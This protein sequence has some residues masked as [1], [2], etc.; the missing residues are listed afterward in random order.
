MKQPAKSRYVPYLLLAPANVLFLALV[1]S[2]LMVLRLSF[3][4]KNLEW[5]AWTLNNYASLRDGIF[6]S[7]FL[8]TLRL[9]IVV[10]AIVLVISFP[11]SLLYARLNSMALKRLILFIILLPLFLNQLLQS[12]GWIIL[13]GPTGVINNLLVGNGLLSRPARLLYSEFGVTIA[14]V[15]MAIPLAV[16]PISSAMRNIPPSYEEAAAILGARRLR[17]LWEVVIPLSRPG[18][19]AAFLLVSAFNI[20]AFVIPLLLG[21]GRVS[22]VPM[23][24]RDQMGPLL[25]WPQGAALAV[26]LVL[27]A[28]GAQRL[29]S[30]LRRIAGRLAS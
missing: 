23:L 8:R 17:V 4:E 22:T 18:I 14:M 29:P 30:L 20:S 26:A 24:I 13:L 10:T 15:Q 21:G 11:I 19:W 3:G 12:Y 27:F 28:L 1:V 2:A 25:N 7:G 9:T 5:G 16:L 6:I